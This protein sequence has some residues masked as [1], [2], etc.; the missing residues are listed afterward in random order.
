MRVKQHRAEPLILLE[1]ID[2][3]Q[4]AAPRKKWVVLALSARA[5]AGHRRR[6]IGTMV[7]LAIGANRQQV[8]HPCRQLA[9][10]LADGA[11]DPAVLGQLGRSIKRGNAQTLDLDIEG[12]VCS[13]GHAEI[14]PALPADTALLVLN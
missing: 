3:A 12:R 8:D 10:L 2:R 14:R 4:K 11:G 7:R 6:D 13:K 9:D 5:Q 1:K